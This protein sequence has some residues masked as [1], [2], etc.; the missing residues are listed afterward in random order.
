MT[1]NHDDARVAVC[2]NVDCRVVENGRC[3]EGFELD[4]CPHYLGDAPRESEG[5]VLADSQEDEVGVES[6]QL[7]GADALT[8]SQASAILRAGKALVIAILGPLASGKT[9]LVASLYDLFQTGPVAGVK[10]SGSRTLHAFERTCHDA[11]SPSRRDEPHMYRTHRGEVRF[12]HLEIGGGSAGEGL[13]LIMGDRSGEDYQE[14]ADDA[15]I[16]TAF[17]EVV[18]ADSLTVL[19]DGERLLDTGERHNLRSEILLILQALHDGNALQGGTRL[20]LVL[21]K[22][23][24]VKNSPYTERAVRDFDSLYNELCRRFGRVFSAIESFQIAALPKTN[25]LKRGKGVSDLLQFW[26]QPAKT[27]SHPAG[28]IPSFERAFARI[29]PL[30]ELT[31]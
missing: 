14:A 21:T 27:P 7:T 9:S 22:L 12:Y 17:S 24:A 8:P 5:G 29:M 28:L 20:A 2:G 11:R 25:T 23:D 18:R 30:D 31:E 10:F 13:S 3:V 26:L 6:V 1:D 4:A 15:S 19:V 16:C